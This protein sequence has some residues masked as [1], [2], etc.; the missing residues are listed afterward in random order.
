[1]GISQL[2][3]NQ[4]TMDDVITRYHMPGKNGRVPCPFHNGRDYNLSYTAQVYHCWVCGA[5][6]NVIGFVMDLFGLDY[7]NAIAKINQD[8]GLGLPM[9]NRMTVRQHKKLVAAEKQWREETKKR[10]GLEKEFKAL[11]DEFY[12]LDSIIVKN[13]PKTPEEPIKEKY[14]AAL[15]KIELVKYKIDAFDET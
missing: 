5:K 15:K 14:A 6:G 9:T 11:L 4:V 7:K 1:M 12:K 8:F 13:R 3:Y 10:K 2:I